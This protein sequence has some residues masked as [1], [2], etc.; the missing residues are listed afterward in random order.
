MRTLLKLLLVL[1]ATTAFGDVCTNDVI[2]DA[3][4]NYVR[5]SCVSKFGYSYQDDPATSTS[6]PVQI[7]KND[8][9]RKLFN[10]LFNAPCD[11]S[12]DPSRT[13]RKYY[14]CSSVCDASVLAPFFKHT[15]QMRASGKQHQCDDQPILA[16]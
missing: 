3:G 9:C 10:A 1:F 16:L 14:N 8:D 11:L 15:Q 5:N 12:D 6:D 7:C 13:K 4:M 2:Y